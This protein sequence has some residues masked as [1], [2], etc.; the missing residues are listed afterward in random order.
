MP[1]RPPYRLVIGFGLAVVA[2]ADVV[3]LFWAAMNLLV[4]LAPEGP[5]HAAFL[6]SAVD[7]GLP[8]VVVAVAV[9]YA[10]RYE[11]RRW[12][13]N[14]PPDWPPPPPSW[15]PPRNWQPPAYLSTP[16]EGWQWWVTSGSLLPVWTRTPRCNIGAS[17]R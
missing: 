14:V 15:S 13:F 11:Q 3:P 2:I 10:W 4:G 8:A 6:V 12:R 7:I 1:Q 9:I 17:W 16:P 5:P